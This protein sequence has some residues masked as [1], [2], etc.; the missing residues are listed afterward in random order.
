MGTVNRLN[1]QL[2][3]SIS[4]SLL[5][6]QDA[7]SVQGACLHCCLPTCGTLATEQ[8]LC[9][10]SRMT[11]KGTG[12]CEHRPKDGQH[13]EIALHDHGTHR[14][15]PACGRGNQGVHLSAVIRKPALTRYTNQHC[16]IRHSRL[17]FF[18]PDIKVLRVD[19]PRP[20]QL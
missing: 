14:A 8:W 1:N 6:F 9:A 15:A 17:V 7:V 11:G 4:A 19:P 12:Q 20:P 16:F 5:L 2:K 13:L 10:P 18:S 3:S